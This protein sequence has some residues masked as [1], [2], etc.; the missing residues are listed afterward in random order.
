MAEGK[1][2]KVQV[3]T[4]RATYEGY[5]T[6]PQ[7]RKRVSDVLNEE[8]RF[9]IN[10]TEVLVDGDKTPISFVSLNKNMIESIIES[11]E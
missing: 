6:I 8:E 5:L 4:T 7:M 9:F 11:P 1:R 3:K 10:L 2:V